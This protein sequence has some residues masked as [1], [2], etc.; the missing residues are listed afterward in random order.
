MSERGS[1]VTE[2]IDCDKC[3]DG[4]CKVLLKHKKHLNSIQIPH[5]DKDSKPLPIIAGKIGGMYKGEELDIFELELIPEIEELIC[6]K[7]RIAVLAE[8]EER[9]FT[10]I[11]NHP[12]M[13]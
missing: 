5:W 11:P 1:F 13:I 12:S 2:Y 3:F 8:N 9:I 6:H 4:I 7:V 10:A